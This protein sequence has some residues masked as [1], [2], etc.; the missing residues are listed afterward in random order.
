MSESCKRVLDASASTEIG[1]WRCQARWCS[2]TL[3]SGTMLRRCYQHPSTIAVLSIQR[4]GGAD[5]D[6]EVPPPLLS[7]MPCQRVEPN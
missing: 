2:N 4:L 3:S 5:T 6:V 7:A 1:V